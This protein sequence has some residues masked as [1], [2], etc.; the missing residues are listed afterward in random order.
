[1]RLI[2]DGRRSEITSRGRSALRPLG[3]PSLCWPALLGS[4]YTQVRPRRGGKHRRLLKAASS[5]NHA[6]LSALPMPARKIF[7]G[8]NEEAEHAS[9]IVSSGHLLSIM[10]AAQTHK[11]CRYLTQKAQAGWI[12]LLTCYTF[13]VESIQI[14]VQ[15]A[16]RRDV[17]TTVIADRRTSLGKGTRDMLQSLKA[18]RFSGTEV[19]LADGKDI[20]GFYAKV[21]R[22][23]PPG[24]GIQHSKTLFVAD[25]A[26]FSGENYLIIGS[27]N[28]TTSSRCNY[29]LSSLIQLDTDGA[30]K[31]HDSVMSWPTVPLSV[32]EEREFAQG[33]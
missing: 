17:K 4:F 13:D 10:N 24:R 32:F 7:D 18:M 27:C 5:T 26:D 19:S 8:Y 3:L 15:E 14:D 16:N 28:W 11:M 25:N 29:E 22:S 23:V 21:G 30:K 9:V 12:W 6:E 20:Q 31:H 1:M 2:I 33:N